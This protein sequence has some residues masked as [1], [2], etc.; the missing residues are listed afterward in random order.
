MKKFK[1][2]LV[3][4]AILP[5]I[6]ISL[7]WAQSASVPFTVSATIPA[8]TGVNIV[9]TQVNAS[10][11]K[12]GQQVSA[13][14]FDPM[15][16]NTKFGV[17]FPDHYFAIDVGASGG[18]GNPNVTVSYTEGA[19]PVGQVNGLGFKTQATFVKITGGPAPED[20]VET[21]LAAHPKQPLKELIGGE[22]VSASEIAGGF[23]RLY[24]GV[25]SGDDAA[26]TALGGE[27]FTL[28]DRPGPYT[29]T[30]TVSA[31]LQ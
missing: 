28:A 23:L 6:S 15:T 16:L 21:A 22:I 19:K 12:F 20:Q 30:L 1:I 27:P 2:A 5:F 8:A 9:A 3:L 24:V 14:D 18:A 7:S 10:D 4:A 31:T 11:N 25:I 13:L 26:V 29:G 17:F